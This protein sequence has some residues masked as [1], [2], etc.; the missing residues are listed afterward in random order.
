[1]ELRLRLAVLMLHA[2]LVGLAPHLIF[3]NMLRST[4]VSDSLLCTVPQAKHTLSSEQLY[5][6]E[7]WERQ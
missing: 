6:I 7:K 3:R 1:M 2:L 5:C 4:I